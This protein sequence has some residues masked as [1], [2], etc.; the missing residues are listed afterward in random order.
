[1]DC[2]GQTWTVTD[3]HGLSRTSTDCHGQARTVTDKHGLSR[4]STGCHGQAR[5]V[6]DNHGLSRTNTGCHGQTRT[7]SADGVARPG[8]ETLFSFLSI[9]RSCRS[10]KN[11]KTGN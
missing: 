4:T 11:T 8:I 5:A 9:T 1:M 10:L 7:C 3:K 2:H 6:T